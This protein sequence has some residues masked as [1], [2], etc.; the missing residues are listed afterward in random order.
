MQGL[1]PSGTLGHVYFTCACLG[2]RWP[3]SGRI[4]NAAS[5]HACD[6]F[7]QASLRRN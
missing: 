4:A 1:E 2:G 3:A 7:C 6:R 5:S